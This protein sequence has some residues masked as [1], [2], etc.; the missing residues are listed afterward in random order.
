ML[1]VH[2]CSYSIPL[3][4]TG[5][6][7]VESLVAIQLT[8]SSLPQMTNEWL[9]APASIDA[10]SPRMICCD[11]SRGLLEG[12][13]RVISLGGRA[14]GDPEFSAERREPPVSWAWSW[15]TDMIHLHHRI[16]K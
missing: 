12:N 8:L 11:P 4:V 13:H 14:E 16:G 10:P 1:A 9:R 3:M 15:L 6:A 2:L 5:S 7:K